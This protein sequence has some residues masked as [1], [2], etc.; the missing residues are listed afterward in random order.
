MTQQQDKITCAPGDLQ[1]PVNDLA[2]TLRDLVGQ[3]PVALFDWPN[4]Q[5]AGDHFIWL[6]EKVLLKNRLGC[7]VLYECSLDTLDMRIVAGLPPETVL[8]M[9]GGGNLGDL[10]VHHQLFRE[11]IIAAF[12]DR[13]AIFMPQTVHFASR[14]LLERS[15]RLMMLHPDLHVIA[16][17]LDSLI[18]LRSQ[19]GLPNCYLHI[20]SA[21]ALQD[22]VTA[23]LATITA[24]PERETVY[25]LRR[26]S[27]AAGTVVLAE[28]AARYD[29]GSA[30][31]LRL[32]A[33][34][35]PESKSIDLARDTFNDQFDAYSWQKLCA[36]VRLFSKGRRIVTDRLHGH[37]LAIMM[38]KEHDLHDNSYGKNSGFYRTWTHVSPLVTFVGRMESATLREV[39]GDRPA[40]NVQ[41]QIQK[42]TAFALQVK[43]NQGVTLHQQ[44]KL[45]QAEYIYRDILRQQSNHFGALH[46]LGVIAVQLQQTERGIALIRTAIGQNANVAG[47]HNNLGKALL[48]LKRPTEALASF[49]RA[50]AL[51]S[52]LAIAHN[53]R[54]NA[55]LDLKRAE[56][57]L[58]S[59]DRALALMPGLAEAHNNRGLVLQHLMRPEDAL[60]S[61]DRAIA[62]EPNFAEAYNNRGMALQD[63]R[64]PEDALASYD[65]A[66]ALK[67]NFAEAYNNRGMALQDLKRP[68]DALASYDKAVALKPDYALAHQR[69]G[70][71][72]D[73]L[74]RRDE[75]FACYDKAFA[76]DAYSSSAD[77]DRMHANVPTARHDGR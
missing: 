67:P 7:N 51:E 47:A 5:N 1:A 29:W 63:L 13:R 66:I 28:G 65:R 4:Y 60:A 23:L 39:K 59:C 37:I 31:D 41:P 76:L 55:L 34:D 72:L 44:G 20:D 9:Q 48:D 3:R 8:V 40:P 27:E 22:I 64:R 50:I 6:G 42:P 75:A 71:A 45:T 18:T 25:L 11:M 58:A 15:A 36:A 61:Y 16:R 54:A 73:S 49:D 35:P 38:G 68:E 30:N 57:A 70:M 52:D 32:F 14:E 26:D 33:V 56:E 21:F 12:P 74:N 19:M 62:L 24:E 10:Y 77:G 17:D 2:R 69:R 53:N 43:F 46:L